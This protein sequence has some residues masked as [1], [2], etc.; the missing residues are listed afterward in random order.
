MNCSY[1]WKKKG[2]GQYFKV[3]V[4]NVQT[5]ESL[6]L[7]LCKILATW[8]MLFTSCSTT[9]LCEVFEFAHFSAQHRQICGCNVDIDSVICVS[10]AATQCSNICEPIRR[11]LN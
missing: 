3:I 9:S 10:V 1:I 2:G 5:T 8:V 4:D 11:L 7:L 6:Q